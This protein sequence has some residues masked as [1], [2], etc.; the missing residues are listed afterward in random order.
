MGDATKALKKLNWKPSIT[1]EEIVS[2]MIESDL[3]EAKKESFLLSQ[4]YPLNQKG[5]FFNGK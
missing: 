4:G 3:E 5:D 1:L 2:D